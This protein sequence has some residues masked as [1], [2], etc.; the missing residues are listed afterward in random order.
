MSFYIYQLI[1][2]L[3]LLN[4]AIYLSITITWVLQDHILRDSWVCC[5][6]FDFDSALDGLH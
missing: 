2:L 1:K 6:N 5:M 4:N 3:S